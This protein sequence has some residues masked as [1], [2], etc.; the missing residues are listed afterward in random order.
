MRPCDTFRLG[1]IAVI[2]FADIVEEAFC[3]DPGE[4]RIILIDGAPGPAWLRW[5]RERPA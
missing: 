3:P 5:G 4:A 1:E 2:E